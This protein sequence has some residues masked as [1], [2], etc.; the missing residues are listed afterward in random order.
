MRGQL[1]PDRDGVTRGLA[2]Q[3]RDHLADDLVEID[4]RPLRRAL[5]EEQAGPGE[6]VP[7]PRPIPPARHPRRPG[8][9][10]IPGFAPPRT[11]ARTSVGDHPGCE[12]Y[13]LPR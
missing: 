13:S 4:R 3:E 7:P 9:P 6:G 1:G 2:A 11:A 5:L 12:A 10:G 8:F